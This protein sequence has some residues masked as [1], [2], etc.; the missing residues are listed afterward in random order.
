[1]PESRTVHRLLQISTDIGGSG[2]A[3]DISLQGLGFR[4]LS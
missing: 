2:V 3:Q 1:M 4:V